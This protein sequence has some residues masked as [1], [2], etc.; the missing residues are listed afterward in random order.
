MTSSVA[1]AALPLHLPAPITDAVS[2]QKDRAEV[3]IPHDPASPLP[4]DVTSG[5]PSNEAMVDAPDCA[6]LPVSSPACVPAQ[7]SEEWHRQRLGKLT[8]SRMGDVMAR[9]K[10][11]YGAA[12]GNY[13]AQLVAERLCGQPSSPYESPSMAWG[14]EYEDEAKRAYMFR[15]DRLVTTAGF[16][17]HPEIAMSGA[18]PDGYVGEDGLI[19]IKAPN[20]TTHLEIVLAGNVP[21]KYLP[22]IFWQLAC[23]G[24]RWCDFVSYDPRLPEHLRFIALRIARDDER[25]RS[26]E[27]EARTFLAEV[28]QRVQA[29]TARVIRP[30]HQT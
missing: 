14:K 25:I 21:D 16:V 15:T 5:L 6:S 1:S 27:E 20:T 12:R 18:S 4:E 24:R 13:L 28:E 9:T 10:T 7:G 17:D 23:T 29:I 22:Q 26:L 19:E 2:A 30:P 11:G 3:S 8:A